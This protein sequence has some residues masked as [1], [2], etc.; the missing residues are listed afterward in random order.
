MLY[1]RVYAGNLTN[2]ILQLCKN[3]QRSVVQTQYRNSFIERNTS[4]AIGVCHQQT[5]IVASAATDVFI[6]ND[7]EIIARFLL[8]DLRVI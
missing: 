6:L 4:Q 3:K 5:C 7:T 2:K 8:H 1:V